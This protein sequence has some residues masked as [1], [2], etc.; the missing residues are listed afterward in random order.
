MGQRDVKSIMT[1]SEFFNMGGYG[2]Y[3]WTSFGLTF[4]MLIWQ[5]IQPLLEQKSICR[6]IA[7]NH[8]RRGQHQ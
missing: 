1:I 6:S 3:V 8:V 2:F 7:K 4:V 5:I